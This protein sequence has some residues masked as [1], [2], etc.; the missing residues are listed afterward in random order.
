MRYKHGF[1]AFPFLF[2]L[3]ACH[4]PTADFER[5]LT[6][7]DFSR[8]VPP[9]TLYGP[10][11]FVYRS[12]YTPS[13]TALRSVRLGYLCRPEYS[14]D[15]YDR[16]PLESASDSFALSS[17]LSGTFDVGVP[18]LSKIL[19]LNL[20]TN[21]AK[22]ASITI[23]D[24]KVFAYARDDLEIVRGLLGPVC[25][26]IV[27]RNIKAGNAYQIEQVL[28]A[29]VNV[30]IAIDAGASANAKANIVKSLASFGATAAYGDAV[31]MKGTALFYGAKLYRL[32]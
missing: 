4:D 11:S 31:E 23:S 14:I 26:R 9:S 30:K 21:A 15:R 3:T 29:T 19:D 32:E 18:A 5:I 16:K 17:K 22:S 8:A 10:G 2:L 20:K 24:V 6:D 13:D 27:A 1:L 28:Q 7:Y 12:K 25:Q